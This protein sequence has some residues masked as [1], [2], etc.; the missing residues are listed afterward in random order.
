MGKEIIYSGV[1]D[2]KNFMVEFSKLKHKLSAFGHITTSY[3]NRQHV[4]DYAQGEVDLYLYEDIDELTGKGFYPYCFGRGEYKYILPLFVFS[5]ST[6]EEKV[7]FSISKHNDYELNKKYIIAIEDS[8]SFENIYTFGE[9]SSVFYNRELELYMIR[10]PSRNDVYGI[11]SSEKMLDKYYNYDSPGVILNIIEIAKIS[12][13]LKTVKIVE[14]IT[15]IETSKMKKEIY[16]LK[17]REGIYWII[18]ASLMVYIFSLKLYTFERDKYIAELE[19]GISSVL[20][21]LKEPSEVNTKNMIKSGI[22]YNKENKSYRIDNNKI[23]K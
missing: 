11:D 2:K 20:K 3:Q 8:E 21:L 6:K 17:V 22:E 12:K 16:S 5:F 9:K 15:L 4:E 18:I 7:E 14:R 10:I 23:D 13:A 19:N 1:C